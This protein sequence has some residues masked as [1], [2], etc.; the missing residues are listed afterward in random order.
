LGEAGTKAPD[1]SA[2]V[3]ALEALERAPSGDEQLEA[4]LAEARR[5]LGFE[6]WALLELDPARG[7]LWVR[8]LVGY[9]ARRERVLGHRFALGQ[10]IVGCAAQLR[11][12]LVV[13]D[14]RNDP[15]YVQGLPGARS[16]IAVPLL[17]RGEV[18]AVLAAES[19]REN[20]FEPAHARTLRVLGQ[21]VAHA[22][23][24][25]RD[26]CEL[27]R[28]RKQLAALHRVSLVTA[29]QA[30]LEDVLPAVLEAA[31]EVLPAGHVA[32]LLVEPASR[33]LRL[34][35]QSGEPLVAGE[36]R[37]PLGKGVTG[38]CG[39]TGQPI[40]VEDLTRETD[41]LPA[42]AT[43]R[44]ELAVPL[45]AEGHVLGVLNAE[46]AELS[47]YGDGELRTLSVIAQQ[48]A[49]A[50]RSAQLREDAHRLSISDPLTGLFN[51]RHFLELLEETLRRARRYRESFAVALIDVDRFK[52]LNDRY[53][54]G[55]GDRALMAAAGALRD[56]VRDTD[57][58]ARIGGDEFGALLLKSDPEASLQVVE[59][60]RD[61]LTALELRE[62]D[63]RLRL[64][65][66]AGIA[67]Y[68]SHGSDAEDLLGRAGA[69]LDE[70]K[71]AGRNCVRLVAAAPRLPSA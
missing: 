60:L 14:V 29:D 66:S 23:L 35:A 69:A 28:R 5:L 67:L 25:A 26:G 37:V 42:L 3:E 61:A 12:A 53:G 54:H 45:C 56:W 13:G 15:R 10:G 4:L 55:A 17:A 64:G 34:R 57:S 63:A 2:L 9:G 46:S 30:E 52:E 58:V 24:A 50:L 62:G 22:L 1:T 48:T 40:V 32:V 27:S 41:A 59:R 51:R 68:P 47:A 70:A 16:N 20:A 7:D 71:R 8:K 18:V 33:T 43:S 44:S 36:L 65:L 38:R 21:G 11:E 39:Q 49:V 19:E 6:H 31:R